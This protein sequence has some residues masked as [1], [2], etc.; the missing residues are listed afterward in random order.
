MN[1][2]WRL[3]LRCVHPFV[4]K[5]FGAAVAVLWEGRIL[6]VRLSYRKGLSL[7]GGRVGKGETPEQAAVRELAEEVGIHAPP[8]AIR[9]VYA[10]MS[11]R[12][13]EYDAPAP[14]RVKIDDREVI[15]AKFLAPEEIQ[16]TDDVLRNYLLCRI[17][18]K[19]RSS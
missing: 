18:E 14:P 12:I 16:D 17:P 6:V 4:P 8:E 19:Y 1:A 2:L 10:S 11:G 9:S 5:G 7:P 15:E 13:F 3:V